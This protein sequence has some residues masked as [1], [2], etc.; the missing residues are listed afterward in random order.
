M[1]KWVGKIN[2][3]QDYEYAWPM[4]P[5]PTYYPRKRGNRGD[6]NRNCPAGNHRLNFGIRC[7]RH[8][9]KFWRRKT[10]FGERFRRPHVRWSGTMCE[11]CGCNFLRRTQTGSHLFCEQK[12]AARHR[13]PPYRIRRTKKKAQ[14]WQSWSWTSNGEVVT[15]TMTHKGLSNG[16]H[17]KKKGKCH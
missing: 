1:S 17:I 3:H 15:K 12:W 10:E 11:S 2:N 8:F 14:Q 9:R 16:A 7:A 6:S 13:G 4:C 5:H